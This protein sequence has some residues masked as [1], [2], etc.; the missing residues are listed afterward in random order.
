M[1]LYFILL[2]LLQSWFHLSV[3]SFEPLA[4]FCFLSLRLFN[5]SSIRPRDVLD[6]VKCKARFLFCDCLSLLSID[7]QCFALFLIFEAFTLISVYLKVRSSG[8]LFSP[9]FIPPEVFSTPDFNSMAHLDLLHISLQI[10]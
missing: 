3:S 4:T 2:K 5:I 10:S 6:P 8:W 7:T 9:A 1:L